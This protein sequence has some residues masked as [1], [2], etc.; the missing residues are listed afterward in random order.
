MARLPILM[1]AGRSPQRAFTSAV[2]FPWNRTFEEFDPEVYS[3]N[4]EEIKR[5]FHGLELVASDNFVSHAALT[6]IATHFNNKYA[7][8]Y[9][10]ARYYGGTEVVDKLERLCQKRAL[11]A[12]NLDPNTWAV[13]VQAL[14]GSVA[15]L[16]VYLAVAP[17]NGRL[18]GLSLADG[19]H[20]THGF[21]N[22]QRPVSA[23]ATFWQSL[24]YTINRK[25]SLIDYN[26]LAKNAKLFNPHVIVAGAS[27]YPRNIDYAAM[28]KIA[29]S[30]GAFLLADMAH[31]AGLVAAG[32]GPSPFDHCDFVTTTTHKT[33]RSV[34]GAL[35]FARKGERKI[36]KTVT[37]YDIEKKLNSAIFPGLQGGPHL[38]QIAGIAVSLKEAASP[39]F[40]EYQR[41]L[42]ANMQSLAN[43]LI[44]AGIRLV[45][46]GSDNHLA[47][48]D[49][50]KEPIDGARLEW[51]LDRA[52]IT[53]NKNT[54]PGDR[55]ARAPQGVRVG[56]PALT[57][58]GLRAAEFE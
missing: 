9:P 52:N 15:N 45:T 47:L 32:I 3:L 30:C 46:G 26:D 16:A 27:A 2:P 6:A 14:S 54:I 25:T 24:P 5:Q 4:Q 57:T 12:F 49:L 8:G 31:T 55:S 7:E 20:L 18:M 44:K 35:I 51:V 39:E 58:R 1:L 53:V 48:L 10:G 22:G 11:A 13:N 41:N 34:R 40:K 36:G 33:L 37:T 28:R 38:H 19:G 21:R 17:P 29:D 50:R 42:V 56:T 43:Y 23:S